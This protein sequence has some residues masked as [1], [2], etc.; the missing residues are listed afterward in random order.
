MNLRWLRR[1]V[2]TSETLAIGNPNN[3]TKDDIADDLLLSHV[4]H[5]PLKDIWCTYNKW[6]YLGN[7]R[8]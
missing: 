2:V 6:R 8:K 7:R 4:Q 5:L 1:A 3:L